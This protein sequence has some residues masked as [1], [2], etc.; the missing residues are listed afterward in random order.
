MNFTDW[1]ALASVVVIALGAYFP[2]RYTAR[3]DEREQEHANAEATR[4]AV[5]DARAEWDKSKAE[6]IAD[7]DY[8]RQLANDRQAQINDLLAGR[9]HRD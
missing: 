4:N 2:L 9:R 1:I 6:L 3:K 7:R 5:A 8:W